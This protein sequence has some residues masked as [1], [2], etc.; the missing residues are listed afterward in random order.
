MPSL[1]CFKEA[2][3]PKKAHF[4]SAYC[5]DVWFINDVTNAA[6][7]ITV[8]QIKLHHYA[9]LGGIL[10]LMY[11]TSKKYPENI[12]KQAPLYADHSVRSGHLRYWA[13]IGEPLLSSHHSVY[14]FLL[15]HPQFNHICD[16]RSVSRVKKNKKTTRIILFL[17][18]PCRHKLFV[19][20]AAGNL[21]TTNQANSDSMRTMHVCVCGCKWRSCTHTHK[22]V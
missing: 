10:K 20:T 15:F 6:K 1:Y 7:K 9:R 19:H 5:C 13:H 2:T 22:H 11:K 3:P 14:H 16:E 12:K 4:Q 21:T 8:Q 18:R 17:A